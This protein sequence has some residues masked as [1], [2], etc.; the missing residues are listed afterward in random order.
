MAKTQKLNKVGIFIRTLISSGFHFDNVYDHSSNISI[1][2]HRFDE[3]GISIPYL[4][5][6]AKT[7]INQAEFNAIKKSCKNVSLILV[8]DKKNQN[9]GL[10]LRNFL[11]KLG[12]PIISLFPYN[13]NFERQ[14][15]ELGRNTLPKGM[16]GK[17]DSLFELAS[18]DCLQLLF[19]NRV[20]K[21]GQ[22]RIFEALPDG[23]AFPSNNL[24]IMYDAKS[25]S[26]GYK[27]SRNSIRTFTDYI[28]NYNSK[29]S[30][31]TGK[32][33]S[34]II[35]SGFFADSKKSLENRARELYSDAQV[36]PV[37]LTTREFSK[38][39][40]IVKQNVQ[41]RMSIDW[42][43]ILSNSFFNANDI[44]KNIN[45]IKKDKIIK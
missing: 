18:R 13:M 28:N 38:A 4:I 42:K 6:L 37:Y 25:Y 15:N 12:G 33:Y 30:H 39:V 19:G 29:Y 40:N 2:C 43:N 10:E 3:F 7:K 5:V 35:V 23:I 41:Y 20:I 11:E 44:R 34:F 21:Y 31:Y 45:K 16:L 1:H 9:E 22:D 24:P 32:I 17:P 27:L 26:S 14:L 36:L 8:G